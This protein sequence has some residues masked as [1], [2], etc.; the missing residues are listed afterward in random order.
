[1]KEENAKY[2]AKIHGV[3]RHQ[4]EQLLFASGSKAENAV[5]TQDGSTG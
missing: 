1:M 4:M 5:V 2:A 3:W